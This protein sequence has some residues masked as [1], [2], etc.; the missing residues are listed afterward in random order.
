M[1][2]KVVAFL[3]GFASA[4]TLTPRRI[5]LTTEEALRSDWE[6]IGG[7]IRAVEE[8]FGDDA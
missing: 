4:F 5:S 8:T 2:D 7:D 3:R 1:L 6:K